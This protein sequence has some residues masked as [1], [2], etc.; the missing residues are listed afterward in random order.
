[1]L[2]LCHLHMLDPWLAPGPCPFCLV[3]VQGAARRAHLGCDAFRV[4]PLLTV[5]QS[6][7]DSLVIL[8]CGSLDGLAW[9][10]P[11][12]LS[13]HSVCCGP[14]C[15]LV[16]RC[17][18]QVCGP[19]VALA[20]HGPSRRTAS[21]RWSLWISFTHLLWVWTLVMPSLK[22][23]LSCTSFDTS[24]SPLCWRFSMAP[25]FCCFLSSVWRSH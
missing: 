12:R 1:M 22:L 23:G 3:P 10:L 5:P 20:A 4:I 8:T 6:H 21:L 7:S 15:R 14:S 19:F 16:L 9:S 17:T 11:P 2:S 25:T 18:H 13:L 24:G